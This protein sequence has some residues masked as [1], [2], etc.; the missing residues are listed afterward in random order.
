[1]HVHSIYTSPRTIGN[2]T[3]WH[4][5]M[6]LQSSEAYPRLITTWLL[7]LYQQKA[8]RQLSQSQN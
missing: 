8:L 7:T 4:V 5:T 6:S 2:E 1:M 3:R